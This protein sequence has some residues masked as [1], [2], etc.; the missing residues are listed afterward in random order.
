MF[1]FHNTIVD[2]VLTVPVPKKIKYIINEKKSPDELKKAA[3]TI[4]LDL[5]ND[6]PKIIEVI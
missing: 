6:L 4:G 1:H 5:T 2:L 3:E